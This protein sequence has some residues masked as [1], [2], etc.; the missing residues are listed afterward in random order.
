MGF[1]VADAEASVYL[2]HQNGSGTGMACGSR[3]RDQSLHARRSKASARAASV[4]RLRDRAD[5]F[6]LHTHLRCDQSTIGR[7]LID[8]R[9]IGRLARVPG[10]R[11]ALR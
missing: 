10:R 9:G 3:E 11:P 6:N 4:I 8:R 5:L 2:S 7:Y 1:Q